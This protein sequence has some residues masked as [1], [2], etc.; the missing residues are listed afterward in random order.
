MN[1]SRRNY[2]SQAPNNTSF[3]SAPIKDTPNEVRDKQITNHNDQKLKLQEKRFDFGNCDFG[4]GNCLLFVICNLG[5]RLK[6]GKKRAQV[7]LEATLAIVLLVFFLLGTIKIFVWCTRALIARH[8]RY[9]QRRVFLTS[10]DAVMAG[11]HEGGATLLTNQYLNVMQD[12]RD[13]A[14][15]LEVFSE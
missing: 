14:P 9:E 6:I 15:R 7:T 1:S 4:I 2:K 12:I 8:Q 11:I 3:H 13:A 10:E 5:F